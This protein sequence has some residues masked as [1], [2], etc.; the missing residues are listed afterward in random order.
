[1]PLM[2]LPENV[3]VNVCST[4]VEITSACNL[5]LAKIVNDSV[6]CHVGFDMEWEY[7]GSEF[8]CSSK[9]TPPVQIA[10]Q[11]SVFLLRTH[12]L[13]TLP[14]PLVTIIGSLQIVKIGRNIG[15]DLAKLV[16]DFPEYKLPAKVDG[17]LPG[18]IE[19]GA[20]AKS[21]NAIPKGTASLSA[22]TT[23]VQHANLSKEAR[24]SPWDAPSLN[25]SQ[26]DYA[27]LDAWVCLDIWQTLK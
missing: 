24:D 11:N 7:S 27:A 8:S 12:L 2:V 21:K 14:S 5:I 26:R 6:E 17:N 10:F 25:S 19:L 3:S 18:V 13:K 9:K 20:F 22:I 4:E 23:T 15:G 16:R 1:L